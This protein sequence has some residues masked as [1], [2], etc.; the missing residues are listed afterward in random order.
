MVNVFMQDRLG[1]EASRVRRMHLRAMAVLFVSVGAMPVS[2]A[3]EVRILDMKYGQQYS[4][5]KSV[6]IDFR[7]AQ[8][9]VHLGLETKPFPLGEKQ[10]FYDDESLVQV[11]I[12]DVEM[13]TVQ[14]CYTE[15]RP[16]RCSLEIASKKSPPPAVG[17]GESFSKL[18]FNIPWNSTTIGVSVSK[19]PLVQVFGDPTAELVILTSFGTGSISGKALSP[20]AP[21]SYILGPENKPILVK[22]GFWY[23]GTAPIE[24]TYKNNR[25]P[26]D[27]NISGYRFPAPLGVR[28]C[29]LMSQ[30]ASPPPIMIGQL[31][32]RVQCFRGQ[33]PNR[34]GFDYYQ[35]DGKV[36]SGSR[37]SSIRVLEYT[38]S[39]RVWNQ[40]K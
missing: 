32:V 19:K 29:Y 16:V 15:T 8:P 34:V 28:G 9:Q 35:I 37:A 24:I 7:Y 40:A 22:R 25:Y 6:S 26:F 21:D 11:S 1:K 4:V 38:P 31:S 10:S 30:P 23:Q 14:H 39:S 5:S 3:D 13:E 18:Q 12:K 2:R 27:R 36:V 17:P 20:S 33:H